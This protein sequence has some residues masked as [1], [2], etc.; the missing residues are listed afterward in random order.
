MAVFVG[1][2][3]EA[4]REG[5][6]QVGGER[7]GEGAGLERLERVVRL[8]LRLGLGLEG[9]RLEGLGLEGKGLG[10]R[11]SGGGAGRGGLGCGLG[12]RLLEFVELEVEEGWVCRGGDLCV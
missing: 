4:G 2:E 8:R 7:D 11:G 5:G 12:L 9:L 1:L 10:R 3:L 6:V